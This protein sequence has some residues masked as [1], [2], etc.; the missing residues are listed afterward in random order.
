MAALLSFLRVEFLCLSATQM[1]QLPK[2][3]LSN[4]AVVARV[5]QAGLLYP[6]SPI[7][8]KGFGKYTTLLTRM[9]YCFFGIR[10]LELF[11]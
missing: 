7:K 1:L 2:S 5:F 9:G 6:T 8:R 10:N 4:Y 11:S 3:C